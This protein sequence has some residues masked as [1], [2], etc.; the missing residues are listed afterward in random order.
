MSLAR[1]PGV[2]S[3]L[4]HVSLLEHRIK[5]PEARGPILDLQVRTL[6]QRVIWDLNSG[7][8]ALLVLTGLA[9]PSSPT[10][11]AFEYLFGW[12]RVERIQG[13]DEFSGSSKSYSANSE[14]LS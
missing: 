14:F 3:E 5:I 10:A 1:V 12:G 6:R 11:R 7:W 13:T 8:S 2:E 9:L 4:T